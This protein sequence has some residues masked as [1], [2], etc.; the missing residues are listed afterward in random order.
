MRITQHD[1]EL[2]SRRNRPAFF[3]H[4]ATQSPGLIHS[5]VNAHGGQSGKR[6]LDLDNSI[7][8]L[9]L[10]RK[11][12]ESVCSRGATTTLFSYMFFYRQRDGRQKWY[13]RWHRRIR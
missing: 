10:V 12:Q 4:L 7:S 9:K 1:L 13:R 11:N 2:W 3:A 5:A 6:N 8:L